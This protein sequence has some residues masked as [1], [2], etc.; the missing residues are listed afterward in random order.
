MPTACY[1]CCLAKVTKNRFK[2]FPLKKPPLIRGLRGLGFGSWGLLPN[3]GSIVSRNYV[4]GRRI[5]IRL[6]KMVYLCKI[7]FAQGDL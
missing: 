3:G 5:A 1:F 6:H 4:V 2:G 7:R